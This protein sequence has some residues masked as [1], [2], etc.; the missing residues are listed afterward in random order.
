MKLVVGLGNPGAEYK[1]SPHNMGFAVVDRLAQRL[2]VNLD[3]KRAQSLCGRVQIDDQEIWLIQPQT[4]MNLS[5]LS[6]KEWLKKEKCLPSDLL[7]VHDEL[8]LPWGTIQIRQRGSSAGHHGVESVIE[9]LGVKEFVRVRIGVAPDH[10]LEDPVEYL[11]RPMRHHQRKV[12][13]EIV[14]RAADATEMIL[15]E[16]VAKA[17][18]RYNTRGVRREGS[19]STAPK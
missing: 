18:S 14:D 6:I 15:R 3:R 2:R 4:F 12:L 17:M 9:A 5:G 1:Y 10:P 13:D 11:L 8:D 7:V 16:G 19:A